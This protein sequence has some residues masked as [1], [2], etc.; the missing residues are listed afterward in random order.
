MKKIFLLLVVT[1]VLAACVSN[2]KP[3]EVSITDSTCGDSITGRTDTKLKYGD[4]D[5]DMKWKSH[6]RK[7]T[8]FRIKLKP[9]D[10]YEGKKVKIVGI[11]STVGAGAGSS[12]DWL[13]IEKS[14]KELKDA[15]KKAIL[16][17]CVPADVPVGTEYKFDVIIEDIGRYDPRVEV[18]M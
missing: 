10:G 1:T 6:V 17:L 5:I 11:S 13:N 18:T 12:F 9:R 14:A 2:G 3:T 15:G 8:E 16:V 4:D 7:D